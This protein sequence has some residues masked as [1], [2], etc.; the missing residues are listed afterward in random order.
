MVLN[1]RGVE[2]AVPFQYHPAGER[3]ELGRFGFLYTLMKTWWD[4]LIPSGK[5]AVEIL[6][7]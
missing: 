6:R 7:Y 2:T 3:I 1:D 5:I 4:R